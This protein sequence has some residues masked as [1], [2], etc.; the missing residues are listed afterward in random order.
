MGHK[1][2]WKYKSVWYNTPWRITTLY[3]YEN[4]PLS[5]FIRNKIHYNLFLIKRNRGIY[6]RNY[7]FVSCSK[8]VELK[9]IV[10]VIKQLQLVLTI[11]TSGSCVIACPSTILMGNM[12]PSLSI[13][14]T[15]V[16]FP[17]NHICVTSRPTFTKPPCNKITY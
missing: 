16:L 12:F 7:Y 5:L 2:N 4:V 3:L 17:Y 1:H 10:N 11:T 15:R 9:G 6:Y 14:F 8:I 13:V